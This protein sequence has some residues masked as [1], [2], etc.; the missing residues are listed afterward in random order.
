MKFNTLSVVLS[1]TLC[2]ILIIIITTF[3][4]SIFALS[5]ETNKM[6]QNIVKATN[7]TLISPSSN[8]TGQAIPIQK[9]VT[10]LGGN[11]TEGAKN[12]VSNVGIGIKD[13]VR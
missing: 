1:I 8:E 7:Q 4:V 10:D 5:N 2:L 6:E 11:I 13:L 3:N 12:L 9:N